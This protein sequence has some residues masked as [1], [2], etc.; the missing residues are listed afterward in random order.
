MKVEIGESLIYSYLRH[1]RKC[2]FTQMNWKASSCWEYSE[3]AFAIVKDVFS[4]LKSSEE[5]SS[6][7]PCGLDQT[8]KQAE[9]DVVGIDSTG[10]IHAI[11][12]AYH[13]GGL[14]Y[15]S[16]K[17]ATKSRVAKKLLRTMLLLRL[18][19]PNS[20]HRIAFC[21]PKVNPATHD[22]VESVMQSIRGTF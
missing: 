3:E 22:R 2:I 20:A 8:L 15:G 12:I 7:F 11:D 5:F 17:D 14:Q 13:E 9:I 19:Y 10:N 21:S 4:T 6:I 16:E 1:V 18:Y